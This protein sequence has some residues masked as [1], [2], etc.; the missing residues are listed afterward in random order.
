[1]YSNKAVC[2]FVKD[3]LDNPELVRN[4][5]VYEYEHIDVLD[6][7]PSADDVLG[8]C[9]GYNELL[10]EVKNKLRENGWEGDGIIQLLWIPPFCISPYGDTYGT[11]VWH[12]KQENNGTSFI[13][14]Q[15]ELTFDT[16]L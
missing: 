2:S 13:C 5:N 15:D 7:M 1:M 11:I 8:G 14:S 3:C 4:F 10:N 16:F 9:Q 6:F 12:V